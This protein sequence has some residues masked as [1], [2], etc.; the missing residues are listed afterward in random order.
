M[1]PL[2][3]TL[4][5][6]EPAAPVSADWNRPANFDFAFDA[7]T[8]MSEFLWGTWL[9]LALIA[10]VL[11]RPSPHAPRARLVWFEV[12]TGILVIIFAGSCVYYATVQQ[13][14]VSN[15]LQSLWGTVLP[16]AALMLLQIRVI[17][18]WRAALGRPRGGEQAPLLYDRAA[19]ETDS[20]DREVGAAAGPDCSRLTAL[21][22][23]TPALAQPYGAV[24]NAIGV[25]NLLATT[26]V[27]LLAAIMLVWN[28]DSPR[29]C[30][31]EH[32]PA[33]M[34]AQ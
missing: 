5:F 30:T 11:A 22:L 8:P 15:F 18:R 33:C 27:V 19:L 4:G 28:W 7:G 14:D 13:N 29:Y 9:W 3:Y 1:M 25:V 32:T 12:I 34:R 17:N 23:W 26:V 6:R 2:V 20:Q 24:F 31:Y 16:T 21:Q 10:M